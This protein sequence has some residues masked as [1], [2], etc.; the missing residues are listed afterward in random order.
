MSPLS[1][2]S[3][4]MDDLGRQM[5]TFHRSSAPVHGDSCHK[6]YG[7]KSACVRGMGKFL[8]PSTGEPGSPSTRVTGGPWEQGSQVADT[9]LVEEVGVFTP[10]ASKLQPRMSPRPFES[11]ARLGSFVSGVGSEKNNS[12]PRGGSFVSFCD[13]IPS[14]IKKGYMSS[15]GGSKNAPSYPQG[16]CRLVPD[17]QGSSFTAG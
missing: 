15:A 8:A 7:S 14:P 11:E 12:L 2:S 1:N 16:I 9:Q 17:S 6:Q 5:L 13:V 10:K 4:T 3:L